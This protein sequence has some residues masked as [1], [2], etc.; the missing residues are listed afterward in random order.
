MVLKVRKDSKS[1]RFAYTEAPAYLLKVSFLVYLICV[2]KY[3]GGRILSLI[4]NSVPD[5]KIGTDWNF[6]GK[7]A[8]EP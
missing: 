4:E 7:S 3:T 8:Y 6:G 5:I 2:F 1:I